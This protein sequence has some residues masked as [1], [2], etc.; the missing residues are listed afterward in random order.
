VSYKPVPIINVEKENKDSSSDEFK[1]TTLLE[2][3]YKNL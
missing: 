2:T 3:Y 1:H